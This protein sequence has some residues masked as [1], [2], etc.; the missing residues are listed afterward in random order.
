MTSEITILHEKLE[1]LKQWFK[2][3][4]KLPTEINTTLLRRFLKCMN[5]DIEDTK[6]LLELNYQLRNKNEH[7]FINRDPYDEM[8]QKSFQTV[9]M[10]PLPGVTPE[11]YKI[12][13]FRLTEKDVKAQN[14]IEEC[15]AFFLVADVRFIYSDVEE[16]FANDAEVEEMESLASGEIHIVD[17]GNYSLRHM[18]SMSLMTMRTYMN[19][20]QHAY[21]VRLKA[22]HI[23]N[24]PTYLNRMVA[25]TRPFIHE[26]VFKMIHF[27]TDGIESLYEHVPRDMLPSEYGGK[28]ESLSVIKSKWW[29]I[30]TKKRDYLVDPN[31]WVVAKSETKSGWLWW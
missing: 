2:E 23:I 5:G 26:D 28:A 24:C 13:C 21:P 1:H 27:H 31:Q 15:K 30:L 22:M 7:L 19:F 10:V 14:S 25:I 6:Q 17:I 11:N 20:L 16:D 8:T 12:L 4:P 18:A 9:D 29:N 3:N